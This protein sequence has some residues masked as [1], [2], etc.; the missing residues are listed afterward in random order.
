M[1]RFLKNSVGIVVLA[2]LGALQPLTAAGSAV[3]PVREPKTPQTGPLQPIAGPVKRAAEKLET[4]V[5][6]VYRLGAGPNAIHR[7]PGK[8]V[9]LVMNRTRDANA[10]FELV[11][12]ESGDTPITKLGG[13]RAW[14]GITQAATA[15]EGDPGV[16]LLKAV[17]TGRVLCTITI[18]E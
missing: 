10:S 14:V 4:E 18:A 17:S 15:I 9:L 3:I 12:Q 13:T 2:C 5:V 7:K 16:L 1:S 8:F 11:R 6:Q